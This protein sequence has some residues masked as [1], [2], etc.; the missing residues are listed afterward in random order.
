MRKFASGICNMVQKL[1]SM[2]ANNVL[3][4]KKIKESLPIG[5]IT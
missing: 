1:M 5:Y 4:E 2:N 3:V